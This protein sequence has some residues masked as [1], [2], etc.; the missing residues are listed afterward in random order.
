MTAEQSTRTEPGS[1]WRLTP[2]GAL[3]GIVALFLVLSGAVLVLTPP[4]EAFDE[5]GHVSNVIVLSDGD[6]YR[7]GPD[8]GH[9]TNEAYQPPLYYLGLAAWHRAL[10]L[11]SDPEPV[12]AEAFVGPA[13]YR[14]DLPHESADQGL[15]RWLRLPNLLAGAAVTLLT[16]ASARLLTTDQWTP[17]V[18]AATVAFLP[19]MIFLSAFVTNDN[20]ANVL[21]AAVT[22]GSIRLLTRT[23]TTARSLRRAGFVLGLLVG[24]MLVT[25]LSGVPAVALSVIP[26]IVI[27][28][29]RHMLPAML[30]LFALG[31]VAAS[32]WWL[33]RNQIWYG[34]PLSASA[35]NE[36]LSREGRVFAALFG[37]D[38]GVAHLVFS[39][40]PTVL[41][42]N[43]WY[44]SG[45]GQFRWPSSWNLVLWGLTAGALT[46]FARKRSAGRGEPGAGLAIGVTAAIA[47]GAIVSL[48]LVSLSNRAL[49]YTVQGR[50]ALP[51]IVAIG[52]LVAVGWERH[53]APVLLRLALPLLG[54]IG[55]A[56]AIWEDVWTVHHR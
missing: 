13:T 8:P 56:Y 42:D 14:H 7:M 23:P 53:G 36:F 22:Y 29:R 41:R 16:Y 49:P 28:R 51:G 45:W 32:G 33:V 11:E 39:Y 50:L 54:L 47:T 19:R 40:V 37:V 6:W 17:V 48:W 2:A 27:G 43:F 38:S 9:L 46:G 15:V 3:A 31:L 55:T 18:A 21:G 26:V 1:G 25:K 34:D 24:A 4:W 44:S 10:G 5:P 35:T 20:L 12:R 30:A 52:S